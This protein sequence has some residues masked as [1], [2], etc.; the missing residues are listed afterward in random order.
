[1]S[2]GSRENRKVKR[3]Y[4]ENALK[5]VICSIGSQVRYEMST[6]DVSHTGL[7]LDFD[8]PGRF[9]F[10]TSSIMEVW[11]ETSAESPV[12]FNGKMARVVHKQEG[13]DSQSPGIAIRIVQIDRENEKKLIDFIESHSHLAEKKKGSSSVA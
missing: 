7:F 6:F 5:V 12:F 4:L 10:N 13:A 8:S 2:K 3:I 1:M 9:P 11:L